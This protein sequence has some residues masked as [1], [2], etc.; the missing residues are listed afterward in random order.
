LARLTPADD[1]HAMIESIAAAVEQTMTSAAP[2][3][4]GVRADVLGVLRAANQHEMPYLAARVA[5]TAWNIVVPGAIS[6][7]TSGASGDLAWVRILAAEGEQAAS[8]SRQPRLLAELL[9][10]SARTYSAA[11]DWQGA[12]T[13]WVRALYLMD[14]LGDEDEYTRYLEL[15]ATNY[16]GAGQATALAT[17]LVE[18]V[19]RYERGDVPQRAAW[20]LA[21]LGAT[22]LDSGRLDSAI[23]HLHRAD[24]LLSQLPDTPDLRMRRAGIL[25][26]L[27]Q[28]HAH[29]HAV[30]R[31]RTC[32]R[33]ALALVVD[34]DETAARRIRDL[35]AALQ[36]QPP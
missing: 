29:R 10:L 31:A 13:A 15:L 27:G 34:L 35:Q 19:E 36:E 4:P 2:L 30:N 25:T 20:A 28:A 5:R 12:D 32:Y 22:M 16:Q 23:L 6:Q 33:E 26:D 21:R 17:I 1:A 3:S 24:R 18:L 7:D 9:D 11:G 14:K 8:Y